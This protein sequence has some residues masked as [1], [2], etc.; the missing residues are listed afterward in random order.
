MAQT[1]I[2]GKVVEV[3]EPRTGV[4]QNGDPWQLQDIVIEEQDGQYANKLG[5][6]INAYKATQEQ[7]N[8]LTE[9]FEYGTMITATCNVSGREYARQDGTTAYNV[10][11]NVWKIEK[12]DTR[13]VT[14]KQSKP[15]G[16]PATISTTSQL[17][18]G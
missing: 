3:F 16:Q 18:F 5:C 10:N 4:K 11:L 14:P 13:E 1:K 8:I 9:S 12:G 2:Y 7:C 6:T 17:P 15:N